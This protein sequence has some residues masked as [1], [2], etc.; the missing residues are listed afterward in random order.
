MTVI[1]KKGFISKYDFYSGV[2]LTALK[3]PV[4][5]FTP[6]FVIGRTP[7]WIAQWAELKE[8]QNI[9]LQDQDNYIQVNNRL[10]YSKGIYI[11]SKQLVLQ[12]MVFNFKLER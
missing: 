10:K 2:I 8:I 12:L 11:W 9:K 4:E 7:G 5:M 3:I 1:S 6:I